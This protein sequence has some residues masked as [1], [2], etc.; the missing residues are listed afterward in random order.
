MNRPEA[1]RAVRMYLHYNKIWEES[2]ENEHRRDH[3]Q[4]LIY[5]LN[6]NEEEIK[7]GCNGKEQDI[8]WIGDMIDTYIDFARKY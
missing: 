4:N 6:P 5:R 8:D 7:A 3:Y 2:E 1:V